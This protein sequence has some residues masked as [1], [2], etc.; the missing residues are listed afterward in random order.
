MMVQ[1]EVKF[2]EK[3]YPIV[4]SSNA[5]FKLEEKT[6]LSTER[7]GLLMSAGRAGYQMMQIILWSSLEAARVK[8]RSRREPFTVEEVGDLLDEAGGAPTVWAPADD[9]FVEEEVNGEKVRRQVREP[10]EDHPIAVAVMECWI[11]AFPKQREIK[12]ANPPIASES[13]QPGTTF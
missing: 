10:R 12:E 6:G 8:L 7:I 1:K 11:S 9:G 3:T 13:D 2:G 4:F 5:L